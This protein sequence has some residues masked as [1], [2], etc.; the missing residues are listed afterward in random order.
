[1]AYVTSTACGITQPSGPR[2]KGEGPLALCLEVLGIG[3]SREGRR[4]TSLNLAF[5]SLIPTSELMAALLRSSDPS[6][7]K[8]LKGLKM[9][10]LGDT[11]S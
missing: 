9:M 2:A 11:T 10:S 7:F 4:R 5:F 1:M 3:F 6:V 8:L